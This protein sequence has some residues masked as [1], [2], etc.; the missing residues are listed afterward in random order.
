MSNAVGAPFGV[1]DSQP[2]KKGRILLGLRQDRELVVGVAII[3]AIIF[4]AIIAPVVAALVG[5]GPNDQYPN[6]AISDDGIP[7]TFGPGFLLGAD[8]LGRDVLVRVLY[9]ARSS[10]MIGVAST[11]VAM[12][13]GVTVGLLAGLSRGAF[14]AISSE[15]T[16]VSLAFPMLLTA[17]TVAALN[18]APD[19]GT[20][21]DPSFVV[22][23]II[24]LFSWAYFARVVR[25]SV[26][27]I[28]NTDYV[29]AAVN[30]GAPRTWIAFREVLPNVAP[31]VIVYWAVQLP[32]NIIAE[33]TLS[34]L[35]V[36][37]RPPDPSW[38]SM[39]SAAQTSGLYVAQPLMLIAPCAALFLTVLGFNMISTRLR[40]DLDPAGRG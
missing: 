28:A 34:F 12:V 33:A 24:S 5:H 29:A 15:L 4:A 32:L 27:A 13:I 7:I 35:G 10:L 18:R 17:L 20:Y 30:A 23:V 38:G 14:D 26:V 9:G 8:E 22:V 39:I 3:A 11:T 1:R 36:G 25:G 31:T 16:N 2:S 21:L 37:V 40:V 19:G 6:I